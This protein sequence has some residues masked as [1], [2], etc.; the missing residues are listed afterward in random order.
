VGK[1]IRG[2]VFVG[3][4]L[5]VLGGLTEPAKG[6]HYS[7]GGHW[8]TIA[9]FAAV[10]LIAAFA[11]RRKHAVPQQSWQPQPVQQPQRHMFGRRA[12]ARR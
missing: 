1:L 10:A 11:R 3:A 4:V 12:G 9:L 8:A 7:A 6:P 2:I 5:M